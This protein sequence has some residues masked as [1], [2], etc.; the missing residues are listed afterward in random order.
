MNE[1]RNYTSSKSILYFLAGIILTI[2]VV[3]AYQELTVLENPNTAQIPETTQTQA[4]LVQNTLEPNSTNQNPQASPTIEQ[5]AT[6][7]FVPVNIESVIDEDMNQVGV[8]AFS[9]MDGL[10]QH[11]FIYHPQFFPL[12]RLTNNL[13]DDTHPA[14]SHDGNKLAYSSN[15][16]G[17]WDIF[18]L[19]LTTYTLTNI[20]NME[21]YES[22]PS[23]S[24]DD[25]WLVFE[26]DRS[27]N[28]DLYLQSVTNLN[29]SPIQLTFNAAAEYQPSWSENGRL[30]AYTSLESGNED[31]W[32]AYLD[33]VEERYMNISEQPE[34]IDTQPFWSPTNQNVFWSNNQALGQM[35]VNEN[36]KP[37]ENNAEIVT[38]SLAVFHPEGNDLGVVFQTNTG[39]SVGIFDTN[40]N[41]MKFP[42]RDMPGRINGIT[43]ANNNLELLL[44]LLNQSETSA[45]PANWTYERDSSN[46]IPANRMGL[47]MLR[48]IDTNYPY[49][50]DTVDESFDKLHQA[51]TAMLG[52]D[53]LS[54]LNNAF[55]PIT[56]PAPPMIDDYWLYTGRAFEIDDTPASA[57]WLITVRED[58]GGKT[59]WRIY[60]KPIDQSGQVGDKLHQR[61]WSFDMRSQGNP[62]AYEQGGTY[63]QSIA[64]G[65][66]VDFTE[67]AYQFGW[68]RIPALL[69]WRTYYPGTQHSVFVHKEY[70]DLEAALL[71]LYPPEALIPPATDSLVPPRP[72]AVPEEDHE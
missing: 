38:G 26:S 35:I 44:P 24:P 6:P 67:L 55:V 59:Y 63:T 20:T 60:L 34:T 25:Q 5:T 51:S 62:E 68:T 36:E 41:T 18:I 48:N 42:F 56:Q 66:W 7:I 29:E 37:G 61:T 32:I 12:T 1:Q 21:S 58:I 45:S 8:M 9:M 19:D 57:N 50:H 30:I 27:G 39:S 53:F 65:Y 4:D 54:K 64:P 3:I 15:Q 10:H 11:L 17:N 49:L 40:S 31:I 69:N 33:K 2:L 22:H 28:L 47:V 71:E 23:W 72:T 46:D 13:W 43:W 16:N 70:L 52:W 14:F